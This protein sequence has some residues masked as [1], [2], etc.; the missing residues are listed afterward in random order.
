MDDSPMHR[1]RDGRKRQTAELWERV[2]ASQSE[3]ERARLRQAIVVQNMSVAQAIAK[4]YAARGIPLEDLEQV[5]CLGL[6]KAVRGFEPSQQKDFL[7]Y[8]VP[9]VSGEVKRHFRDLGWAVRPPRRVQELQARVNAVSSSA[10]AEGRA[11]QPAE[12]AVRLGVDVC[13]VVESMACSGAFAPSSLDAP[14][15]ES[16]ASQSIGDLIAGQRNDFHRVENWM[17]LQQALGTLSPRDRQILQR[18]FVDDRTQRQIGEEFG[19]SQMQVSRL[20]TRILS[21]LRA[22]VEPAETDFDRSA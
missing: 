16:E 21:T 1:E 17:V 8:A 20:L 5:A 9:T 12:I 6:V 18:R 11:P 7:S 13:H 10:I 4:R 15:G 2:S 14:L 3:D 19:V 22:Q